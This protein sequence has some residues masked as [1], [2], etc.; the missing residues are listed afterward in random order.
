MS[1]EPKS[2][3]AMRARQRSIAGQRRVIGAAAIATIAALGVLWVVGPTDAPVAPPADPPPSAAAPGD[4]EEAA[5]PIPPSDADL[6]LVFGMAS[7]TVD[8]NALPQ[9]APVSVDLAVPVRLDAKG[10]PLTTRVMSEGREMLV[11]DG[12]IGGPDRNLVRIDVPP[13]WLSPGSYL[14]EIQ[15]RERNHFPLRRFALI[16]D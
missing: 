5:L 9:D 16:V 2:P 13:G 7:G 14:I 1:S 15:T 12:Q 8:A 11:L 10:T 6:M 3:S 4:E